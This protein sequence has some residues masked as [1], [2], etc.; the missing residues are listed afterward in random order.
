VACG[1]S[2]LICISRGSSAVVHYGRRSLIYWRL[3]SMAMVLKIRITFYSILF[4]STTPNEGRCVSSSHAIMVYRPG[5]R[6][7]PAEAALGQPSVGTQ[8]LFK[9]SCARRFFDDHAHR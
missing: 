1:S 9:E 7:G 3:G 4:Y 5:G 2:S 8:R 6:G